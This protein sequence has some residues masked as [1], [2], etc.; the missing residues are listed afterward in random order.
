[1]TSIKEISLSCDEEIKKLL[2]LVSDYSEQ[3]TYQ[4]SD[5]LGGFSVWLQKQ[6][7]EI[8]NENSLT[9]LWTLYLKG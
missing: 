7:C 5:L 1:M 9:D 4:T 8:K 2:D 6:D 3:T